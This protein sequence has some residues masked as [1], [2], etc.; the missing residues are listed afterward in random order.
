MCDGAHTLCSVDGG[1]IGVT[2]VHVEALYVD[3]IQTTRHS[4]QLL[5]STSL[6]I[7][8]YKCTYISYFN[9]DPMASM[10]CS[11]GV[12]KCLS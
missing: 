2:R 6:I 12:A 7:P 8:F 3:L 1:R 11:N 5:Y 4:H 9:S 10:A